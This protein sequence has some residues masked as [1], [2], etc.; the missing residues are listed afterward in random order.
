T[1][2][3][4]DVNAAN[5]TATPEKPTSEDKKEAQAQP[6]ANGVSGGA[7]ALAQ[8]GEPKPAADQATAKTEAPAQP[9][10]APASETAQPQASDVA[11]DQTK[12][13]QDTKDAK[14]S[15]GSEKQAEAASAA[16]N[17]APP[18]PP[19]SRV[20]ESERAR[21][22]ESSASVPGM[23]PFTSTSEAAEATPSVTRRIGNH[24]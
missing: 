20:T 10:A 19:P 18:P 7:T 24:V 4:H 5:R 21:R 23:Q 3:A 2:T 16:G 14:A 8:N 15:P 9:S 13:K 6:A 22:D 12:E 11:K 1:N 17:I